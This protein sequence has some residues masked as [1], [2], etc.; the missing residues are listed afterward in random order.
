MTSAD[1][2]SREKPPQDEGGRKAAGDEIEVEAARPEIAGDS[3]VVNRAPV[4]E[5]HG[6]D[7]L[8]LKHEGRHVGQKEERSCREQAQETAALPEAR[9]QR[10]E[11][12]QQD[13]VEVDV[14]GGKT[15]PRRVGREVAAVHQDL[16]V[17]GRESR[18]WRPL[19]RSQNDFRRSGE[20]TLIRLAE[21][22]PERET[23]RKPE[24]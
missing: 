1:V 23:R 2:L 5:A 6:I 3:T 12:R 21:A 11:S 7:G 10:E 16:A 22:E 15:R 18:D 9:L 17:P 4:A 14:V 13:E 19:E 20:R 8:D 24:A